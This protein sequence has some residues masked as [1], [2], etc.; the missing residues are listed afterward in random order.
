MIKCQIRRQILRIKNTNRRGVVP[1]MRRTL[2]HC[3]VHNRRRVSTRIALW[4]GIH[5]E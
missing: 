3:D 4:V 2:C 5:P 1:G